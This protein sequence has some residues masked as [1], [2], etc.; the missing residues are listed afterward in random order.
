M[1]NAILLTFLL[2]FTTVVSANPQQEKIDWTPTFKQGLNISHWMA[3]HFEGKYADPYR[4]SEKDAKWVAK[5]GF[6]HIRIPV[7]GRILISV[8]GKLIHELME[9][10]DNA[11]GWARKYELGVILDMHYMPGAEFLVAAEDNKLWADESLQA[12]VASMWSQIAEKYINVGNFLR[13][14]VLNEA[15]APTSEMVNDL[16]KLIVKAIRKVDATRIIYVSSNH[17]GK[18][19]YAE[20]VYVFKNDPNVHYMFHTYE[21]LIFTHQKAPWSDHVEFYQEKVTFPFKIDNLHEYF[22][23]GFPELVYNGKLIDESFIDKRFEKLAKWA[24]KHNAEVIVSEFGA[25]NPVDDT[26]A[27]RY[28]RA[29]KNASERHGFGWT[30]WDYK[31][32]FAVRKDG[33]TTRIWKGLFK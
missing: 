33:K 11:L 32:D 19:E 27:E 25:Y 9:S 28:V 6:D 18:F 31:G 16:N 5:H 24:K 22:P 17:F 23:E 29:V 3:Q 8:E 30:I 26:S 7:D 12:A 4:F 21:P 2:F 10:F 20:D 15:V 13:Y 1:K 14:E